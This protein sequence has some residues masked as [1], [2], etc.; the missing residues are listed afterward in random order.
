MKTLTREEW[1][2]EMSKHL[3]N[4]FNDC[5]YKVH[6]RIRIS[7]GLP[8]SRAF[9]P[10]SKTIGQCWARTVSADNHNEIFISPTIDESTMVAA[11]LAHEMVHAIVGVKEGHRKAFRD[12]AVK[13]GLEGK[14]TETTPSADLVSFIDDKIIE[15]GEYPHAKI[16]YTKRKKEGT[17]LLKVSC[18]NAECDY[19]IT[20]GKQYIVRMSKTALNYGEPRCGCCGEFMEQT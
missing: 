16:D 6:K 7:C 18:I 17:R 20:E 9:G 1:L 11:T 2:I 19:F 15:I 10:K 5:G 12:C 14:M 3:E 4:K 13:I 8:S